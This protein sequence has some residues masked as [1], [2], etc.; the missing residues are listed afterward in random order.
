MTVLAHR[1][2]GEGEPLLLLNGGLM[3]IS[4]WDVLMPRLT[5]AHRVIRCDF[6]GQLLSLALGPPPPTMAG[7]AQ[8]LASLLDA[9]GLTRVHLVGASFGAMAAIEFAGGYPDRVQSLVAVTATD[10]VTAENHFE[11][12]TLRSAVRAAAAGGDGRPVLDLLAPYTFSPAWLD[13]HREL[14]EM[15][16]AQFGL[17]PPAWYTGLDALLS[18]MEHLDVRPRLPRIQA[19][20]LVIG[21][22]RD[23]IFPADRSRALAAAIPGAELR[24]IPEAP[25]GWVG[26]DP[27][28]FADILLPF[29]SS[30]SM[31][32]PS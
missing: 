13:A 18:A 4:S 25:H 20:T 3:S 24:I 21:A 6:R 15:R 26:E 30:H 8:D 27:A 17:L 32:G 2:D 1:L 14:F 16:R 28:A 11:E 19:P 23:R 31:K 9:L 7:H 10:V 29:L 12:A 5:G 22:E